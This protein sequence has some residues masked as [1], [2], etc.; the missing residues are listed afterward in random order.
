M[1]S[2]RGAIREAIPLWIALGCYFGWLSI[3]DV[4]LSTT[5]I[6]SMGMQEWIGLPTFLL[7]C[8]LLVSI[9]RSPSISRQDPAAPGESLW[10]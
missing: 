9:V 8:F 7:G 4:I 1:M 2:A 5:N 6:D 10:G 3:F